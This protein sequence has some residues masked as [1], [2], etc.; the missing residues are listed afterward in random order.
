[1]KPRL[2]SATRLCFPTA[3]TLAGLA[4]ISS[5]SAQA[6]S[7]TWTQ[8]TPG[9]Y[10]WSTA[11]NWSSSTIADGAGFN[12]AFNLAV[13]ATNIVTTLDTARTIGGISKG[14]SNVGG[15]NWTITHATNLLTLDNGAGNVTISNG[16]NAGSTLTVDTDILLNSNLV[17]N[18]NGNNGANITL[19]SVAGV[20]SITGAR[21]ITTNSSSG[22]GNGAITF[23]SNINTSGSF[24]NSNTGTA[25]PG[26]VTINGVIGVNV[27]GVTESSTGNSTLNLT[28][29]NTYTSATTVGTAGSAA[30]GGT[31]QVS[32]TAGS[33][34]ASSGYTINGI[35]S[36]LLLDNTAGNVDRLKDTTSVVTLNYGGE[37]SL[38][39]N[40]STNSSETTAS[41]ALGTGSG[42]VTVSSAASRVTTLAVTGGLTRTNFTTALVRGT[43]L[44]Q[45]AATNVSRITLGVAP[46][47]ASFVGTNTLTGG[48]VSDATQALKI[49][50]WLF[51]DTAV[52][53][54][55]KNFVTYDT[56]LG[57]RVLN[58][59]EMT[60]L[61]A[62]S[63]TA[64]N[65]V[66]AVAFNGT[67]TTSGLT[68]NSLL[69]NT[70]TQTLNGSGAL[71]VS[72]GAVAA[73]AATEAIG[74][75]F[76]S[77]ALGNGEGVITA[78]GTNILTINTPVNV[79]SSGGLT[80]A[81]AGTIVL[82][83]SNL[84]TGV[85]TVNQG[86]LQIG[87]GTTGDLGSNTA[88][89]VL[90]GGTLSFGRTNAGLT[91]ANAISGI[92]GVTQNGAGGTTVL[93][94]ANSYTGA[95]TVTTGTLVLSAANTITG[96]TSVAAAGTLQLR[97][98][99]SLGTS[100]LTLNSGATLQLRN[101]ANTTF[102]GT[103]AA[104][105]AGSTMNLE[106]NQAASG[107]GRTLTLGN[108]TF[109]A[110][111]TNQVN[112]TGGNGYSLGLGTLSAPS[113]SGSLW[114][115][116]VNATT[117]PVTI[118]K[119]SAGSFGSALQLQ[120]G[121]AITLNGF[122]F[123]SNA[124]NTLTVS[125]STT[126]VNLGAASAT[127]GRSSGG[128][129]Y[130]L[131]DGTLNLTATTA[132][133]NV[134]VSGTAATPTFT[135]TA[136]TL[137]NTSGSALALA[138]NSGTT[139]GSPNTTINGDFA[140]GTSGST[141]LN[142]LNLGLGTVSLGTTVGTSRQITVNGATNLSLGGIISNGTTANILTK[143][144]TGTLT[145]NGA[146]AYT[147]GTTLN[148]GTVTIGIGGTL[149]ATTGALSV[150]NTN[151]TAAGTAAILNL[152]TAAD[153]TVGTLSGTLAT[154]TSGTN[155]ATINIQTSRNFTVNQTA[156][157]TYAGVI[158]GAGS[159]TLGSLSTN[160]L[161][162]TGANTYTGTTT[163]SA[164]TLA[165]NGSLANTSTTVGSGGRLQGG[166]SIGG[167]VTVQ[168]GGTIA[169][170]N[171]IESVATGALS[172]EAGSTFA[173][174]IDKDAAAG[175]AGDLTAVT[176]N[177]TLD[178]GNLGNLTLGELGG[179]TWTIGEKLTLISYNG[180]WNGGLFNYGGTLA[181][182]STFMLSGMEWLF[183]Y[184]DTAAG[185]NYTGDLTGSSFVTM[186]A[187]PEPN[188][189]AL[190]GGM[191]VLAL[192]RRRRN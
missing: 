93:S 69:F 104:P 21:N 128:V 29:A 42:I 48:A 63:T 177:L 118:A 81:G 114:G 98:A 54:T 178:L 116:T 159:L 70:A 162:L 190:I 107:T 57:L 26:T 17:I 92:G 22:F 183:N 35:A 187:V 41:L 88:S 106:V 24:T 168:S 34:N 27:T 153:T 139:A 179:G 146:N 25:N 109:A 8:A 91:I 44:D 133:A 12:A 180:T 113:G 124:N 28:G 50:P 149:G 33:I 105:A 67:V 100:A 150:T 58:A 85:T 176:G 49:V 10:N 31:L 40:V 36:R 68:V 165:V 143:A 39:G 151:S 157:G 19:G 78:T 169:A 90:N 185:T 110:S 174:E 158:A 188:V 95:T 167:S 102:T 184:D 126:V 96:A 130:T 186:T 83:A 182:D 75:G 51:G 14:G 72:S 191:G 64:A 138:A 52:A 47:G 97:N 43:S 148:Q 189:A 37:L 84:Y 154:P 142:D 16:Q 175:V 161:T 163:V 160:T 155:T 181:D 108:I 89:I 137:N 30:R 4:L 87:T 140:F 18:A 145:L 99:G 166:G 15:S 141:S 60:T 45:S 46:T 172:L 131:A 74:S 13:A 55:G 23:N 11:A 53:G 66:N 111:T 123:G 94:V 136:G 144:G 132:L 170:G 7:G 9:T 173:Y 61:S 156:A 122:E 80:T 125:G 56:T 2:R 1:M 5:Q 147:G 3:M 119:F 82:G 112:V 134:N 101:D 20:H 59:T 164:G 129:A 62:G 38:T 121:N 103:F 73:V 76:S 71:T 117:A 171:S 127:N 32:G 152:A 192:L 120:G 6:A 65:P 115:F 79:T 86:T 77:L 135:I